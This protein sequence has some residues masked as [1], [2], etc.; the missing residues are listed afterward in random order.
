RKRLP[1]AASSFPSLNDYHSYHLYI[2]FSGSPLAVIIFVLS[3][4]ASVLVHLEQQ[5]LLSVMVNL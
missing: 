4:I 2:L 1:A 5:K 3:R